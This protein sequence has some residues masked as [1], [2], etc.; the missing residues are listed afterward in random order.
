MYL[1]IFKGLTLGEIWRFSKIYKIVA[2][3]CFI[4]HD[5]VLNLY[6]VKC[7]IPYSVIPFN[8]CL[9]SSSSFISHSFNYC[10]SFI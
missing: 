1:K 6:V 5:K 7:R 9:E 2:Y 10:L 8:L 3:L 4:I